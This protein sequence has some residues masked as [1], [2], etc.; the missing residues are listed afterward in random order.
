MRERERLKE[1]ERLR[2]R[3][4][5]TPSVLTVE[6]GLCVVKMNMCSSKLHLLDFDVKL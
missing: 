5:F 1:K 6:C 2:E 3:E 4:R